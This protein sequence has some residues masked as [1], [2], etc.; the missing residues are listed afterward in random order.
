MIIQDDD[1]SS[2]I[3][4]DAMP[5]RIRSI[6]GTT[7]ELHTQFEEF[8]KSW[9]GFSLET[10]GPLKKRLVCAYPD[11]WMEVFPGDS[12][13]SLPFRNKVCKCYKVKWE[14]GG[15]LAIIGTTVFAFSTCM[16]LKTNHLEI[17]RRELVHTVLSIHSWILPEILHDIAGFL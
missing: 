11:A 5:Y 16:T 10:D 13:S 1:P 2:L 4:R 3:A 17:Q 7:L 12:N 6:E 14:R 15:V 9:D 8:I